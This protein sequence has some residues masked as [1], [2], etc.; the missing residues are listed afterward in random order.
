MEHKVH[1]NSTNQLIRE[2]LLN[3]ITELYNLAEEE[4]FLQLD[5]IRNELFGT[6]NGHKLNFKI[7]ELSN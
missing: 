6:P 1:V 2:K 7:R 4:S 5:I 3:G